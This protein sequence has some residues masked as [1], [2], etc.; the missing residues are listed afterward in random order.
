MYP[1]G[2]ELPTTTATFRSAQLRR[3]HSRG[4]EYLADAQFREIKSIGYKGRG[5]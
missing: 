3:S 2:L 5:V 1:V 4:G